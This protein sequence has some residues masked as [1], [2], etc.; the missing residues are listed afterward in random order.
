M[1]ITDSRIRPTFG[2]ADGTVADVRIPTGGG[3]SRLEESIAHSRRKFGQTKIEITPS[4][5]GIITTP[6]N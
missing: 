2:Y 6:R 5:Y 1:W 3:C 4:Y